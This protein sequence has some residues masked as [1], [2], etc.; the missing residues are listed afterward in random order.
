[1]SD[2]R[3]DK[4][5][6]C[7]F[8]SSVGNA[9][10][11]LAVTL[12]RDSATNKGTIKKVIVCRTNDEVNADLAR[13]WCEDQ[14]LD[15]QPADQ[16]D[17]LFPKDAWALAIDLDHLALGPMERHRLV[18]RLYTALPTYPVAVAS[19]DLDPE[20]QG[21]LRD[22]GVLVFRRIDR[23]LFYELAAAIDSEFSDFAA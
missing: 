14:G 23:Q 12:R 22:R 7:S 10:K 17:E 16:R 19:Y 20:A 5:M 11:T 2:F 15:F 13:S 21:A 3:K 18:E 1:M 6:F 8:R 9:L 4:P